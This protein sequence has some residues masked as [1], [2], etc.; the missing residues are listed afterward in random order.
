MINL[1][2][3]LR[4]LKRERELFDSITNQGWP[5]EV[6]NHALELQAE[7]VGSYQR[8]YDEMLEGLTSDSED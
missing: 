7:T 6:E 5:V 8:F 2:E 1:L 4:T 3:A